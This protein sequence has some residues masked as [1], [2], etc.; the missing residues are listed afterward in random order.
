MQFAR[1]VRDDVFQAPNIALVT[2]SIT[3]FIVFQ[4]CF[5][6]FYGSRQFDSTVRKKSMILRDAIAA[7]TPLLQAA[8]CE[9]VTATLRASEGAAS[10]KEGERQSANRVALLKA[11]APWCVPTLFVCIAS[12]AVA[13]RRQVWRAEHSLGAA[14]TLGCFST[15]LFLFFA[16]IRPHV[17]VGDIELIR[18]ALHIDDP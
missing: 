2:G 4:G 14:L 7:S 13:A 3:A 9:R 8:A 15:E 12:C 18:R 5:F 16:V 6:Y 11:L 1:A 10:E 17:M